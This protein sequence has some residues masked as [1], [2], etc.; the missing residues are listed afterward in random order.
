MKYTFLFLFIFFLRIFKVFDYK[1]RKE[2]KTDDSI[3]TYNYSV[4]M[5]HRVYYDYDVLIKFVDQLFEDFDILFVQYHVTMFDSY[6]HYV[7]LLHV[8]ILFPHKL[9]LV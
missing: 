3:Y 8:V 1:D 6:I 2:R 4:E 9:F 5:L 7:N